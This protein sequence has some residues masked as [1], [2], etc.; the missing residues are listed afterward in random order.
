MN[1][2]KFGFSLGDFIEFFNEQYP[3]DEGY[4]KFTEL[5]VQLINSTEEARKEL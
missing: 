3:D 2:Q 4:I 1:S 5:F